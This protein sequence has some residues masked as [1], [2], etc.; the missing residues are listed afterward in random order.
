MGQM[1]SEGGKRKNERVEKW[2]TH[3]FAS[4]F[5][6]ELVLQTSEVKVVLIGY[7]AIQ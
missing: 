7:L 6:L 5:C 2:Q 4:Q 1:G 3:M